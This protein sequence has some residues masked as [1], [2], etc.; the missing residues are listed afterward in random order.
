MTAKKKPT[1]K[2]LS[3]IVGELSNFV[4]SM[5][6]GLRGLVNVLK[7]Y[8]EFKGDSISFNQF[9]EGKAKEH[10]EMKKQE[11]ENANA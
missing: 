10:E 5:D 7:M 4:K 9:L 11:K 3:K 6:V 2:E 1:V 8:V